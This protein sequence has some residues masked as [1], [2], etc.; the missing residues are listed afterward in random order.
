MNKS[1]DFSKKQNKKKEKNL[2]KKK[3]K[4]KKLLKNKKNKRIN[5]KNEEETNISLDNEDKKY[6][7]YSLLGVSKTASNEEIRNAYRSLVFLYHPDKNKTDPDA[8]SKFINITRAYKVL[9]NK[10]SRII[11]DETGEYDEEGK[12]KEIIHTSISDFRKKV[13]IQE[14]E[15]YKNKYKNS[16]EEEEDLINFYNQQKGN[17]TYILETIPYSTNKDINRY[18]KI[19]EKLFKTKKLKRND[20]YEKTKNNIKLLNKNNQEEKEAKEILE[21]LTKQIAE[22]NEKRNFNDYLLE[23]ARKYEDEK[24][25]EINDEIKDADFKNIVKGL[26]NKK[27]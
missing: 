3:I 8:S 7:L 12:E 15:N 13:N 16:K 19:F 9:S 23:L 24:I 14:I 2:S 17:I 6:D 21:K 1:V 18:F 20:I 5:Q 10:K 22:R 27:K 26:K 25:D 11:Y 4:E